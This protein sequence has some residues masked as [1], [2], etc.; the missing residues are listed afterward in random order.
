MVEVI[1]RLEY[2]LDIADAPKTQGYM[3]PARGSTRTVDELKGILARKERNGQG[4]QSLFSH[5]TITVTLLHKFKLEQITV[6]KNP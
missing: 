6:F 3:N 5:P 2:F 1:S 4:S